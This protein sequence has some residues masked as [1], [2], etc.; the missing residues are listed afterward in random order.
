[1]Q[2]DKIKGSKESRPWIAIPPDGCL[3]EVLFGSLIEVYQLRIKKVAA[4]KSA[5]QAGPR[6][7]VLVDTLSLWHLVSS[8]DSVR[9]I[10]D[11]RLDRRIPF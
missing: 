7:L 4:P 3:L 2:A 1:V 5:V 8:P 9:R 11:L 10:S 6:R